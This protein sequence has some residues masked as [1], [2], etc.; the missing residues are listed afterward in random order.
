MVSD[1]RYSRRQTVDLKLL[2]HT[3]INEASN[4]IVKT[5]GVR[6]ARN[7]EGGEGTGRVLTEDV[8]A[9]H[10]DSRVAQERFPKRQP[11]NSYVRN[12]LVGIFRITGYRIV[13]NRNGEG[14]IIGTLHIKEPGLLDP[15]LFP[16]TRCD[17][18]FTKAI[19]VGDSGVEIE[20]FPCP[21]QTGL[22]SA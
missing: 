10:R 7:I 1:T 19:G 2:L 13:L 5:G 16:A 12:H 15:M 6:N 9:S 4:R 18:S 14:E 21:V 11:I 3:D 17:K 22:A 8:I 20:S